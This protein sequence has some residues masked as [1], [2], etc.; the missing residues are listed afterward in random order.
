MTAGGRAGVVAAVVVALAAGVGIGFV[1][2]DGG[3]EGED[4]ALGART[5]STSGGRPPSTSPTTQIGGTPLSSAFSPIAV[6]P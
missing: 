1:L 4:T 3:G 2:E 6:T 5:T